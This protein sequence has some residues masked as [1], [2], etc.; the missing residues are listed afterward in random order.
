MIRIGYWNVKAHNNT[1]I[2]NLGTIIFNGS[3]ELKGG[4]IIENY[5]GILEFGYY[6]RNFLLVHKMCKLLYNHEQTFNHSHS[7]I[8][9]ASIFASLSKFVAYF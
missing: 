9:Y 5:N 2:I 7:D 4:S 1:R 6:N 3:M 8:Q